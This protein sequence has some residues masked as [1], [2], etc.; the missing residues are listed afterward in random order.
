MGLQN[1]GQVLVFLGYLRQHVGQGEAISPL[2]IEFVRLD[3]LDDVGAQ[4]IEEIALANV[5]FLGK[6]WRASLDLGFGGGIVLPGLGN[7]GIHVGGDGL[8]FGRVFRQSIDA[9]IDNPLHG[10]ATFADVLG[11]FKGYNTLADLIEV[12]HHFLGFIH[13]GRLLLSLTGGL[14]LFL[15]LFLL[16]FRR[17]PRLFL[18]T[19][20]VGGIL[21]ILFFLG[22]IG[23][24]LSFLG[25]FLFLGFTTGLDFSLTFVFRLYLLGFLAFLVNVGLEELG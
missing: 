25:F 10:E 2:T 3:P 19:G 24:L 20:R 11:L 17:D 13:K 22:G 23:G 12:F 9:A 6:S 5:H 18:L 1:D 16:A 8:N 15:I 7:G 4:F 21:G 14:G